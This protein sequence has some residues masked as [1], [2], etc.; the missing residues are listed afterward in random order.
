LMHPPPWL[1]ARSRLGFH[2]RVGRSAIN[3]SRR[4]TS[5]PA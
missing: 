2:R 3:T 5:F 4:D 1:P